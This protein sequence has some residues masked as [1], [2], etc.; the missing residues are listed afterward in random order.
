MIAGL[1]PHPLHKD[2]GIYWLGEI[3]EQWM[4]LRMKLLFRDVDDRGHPSE[5]LLAATQT[6]GVVR[7]ELYRQRTVVALQNLEL[8]KLVKVNDFVISLRSFQGGIER[9]FDRGIISPAYTVLR[10]RD[11]RL[12]DASYYAKLF[13][14][15]PFIDSLKLYT[16]G[17]RQG[18]NIDYTR[19]ARSILPLPPLPEQ[20]AIVKFLDWAE[21]RIRFVVAARKRRIRLLEEYRQVLIN[22]AVTGKFDV[23]TGKPYPIYKDSGVPWL[24][25]VPEG[26]EIKKVRQ[27]ARLITSNVDKKKVSGEIDVRLCNYVDV[28]K[29][30]IITK[31]LSFMKATATNDELRKFR[32]KKGD[33]VLTKDSEIW[34]DIGV[35]AYVDYEAPDLVYGYHLAILR[36]R[37]E[38]VDA[39]YLFRTLQSQP[40]AVQLHIE[41]TGVTRFG[42]S[43]EAIKSTFLPLPSHPVQR[44]IAE[45]LDRET[46][47][48]DAAIEKTKE[49]IALWE[50]LRETLI[51]DVVTGKLDVREV[52]KRLPEEESELEEKAKALEASLLGGESEESGADSEPELEQAEETT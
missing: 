6:M 26:W 39:K 17:I 5:P 46:A 3:P 15:T 45:Y 37:S 24:G 52:A 38:A 34:T 10:L 19:L 22:D 1:K 36:P 43:Q 50:E 13:K 40:V 47:K 14:S 11:K 25:K 20:R 27:I 35:P 44:T 49:S 48:I 51:S 29:N 9:A 18:Q 12:A 21:R 42:L 33:V 31:D 32:V 16:I 41:A 2:S 30:E 28:Y 4:L 7:K 23:R 8:L